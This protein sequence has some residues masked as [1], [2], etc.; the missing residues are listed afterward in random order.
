MATSSGTTAVNAGLTEVRATGDGDIHSV[1]VGGLVGVKGQAVFAGSG[2]YNYIGNNVDAIVKNQ[3]LKSNSSVGVVAQSDDRLYN[4]AGGFAIG[5]NT[6]VGLGAAVSINKITGSTN[7]L[8]SGGSLAAADSGSVKVTRPQDDNLFTT[9]KLNLTTDRTKLSENR[10]EEEKT[11]IVVDSS[12]THTLI[13]QLS[14]GGVAASGNVGINLDG[15]VNLN[16]IEGKTT[17]K[18]QDAALNT[19]NKNSDVNVNAVDYTNIGSFTGTP[20]VGVGP[21]LG[22][23]IGVSA[24]W[25]TLGRTTAAEI[26]SASGKKDVYAKNL[27]VDATAKHGSSALSF[28]AAAGGGKVGISSGDSIVR[29]KYSNTVNALMKDVNA[30][31]D[32]TAEIKADHLAN[33]HMQNISASASGGMV[34][35]SAGAGVSVID[36][37]TTVKAE[38]ADSDLKAKESKEGKNISVQA[39]NENNWKDTLVTASAAVGI[40]A[41]L[42]ANVAI[43]NTTGETSALVTRSNLEAYKVDVTA[44]DKLTATTTGGVGALGLVGV[45]VS[46][47]LNNINSSVNARVTDGTVK[48]ANDINVKAEEE[49]KFDSSVTG[50]AVG[51][52]GVGVNVAVTSINKGITEAQL[53]T[54]TNENGQ[55]MGTDAGTKNEINVHLNGTTVGDKK[56][57]GVNGAK[58]A[59]G[60]DGV[61]FFGISANSKE[62]TDA[63][64]VQV[65]LAV[66]TSAADQQGV[67]TE[68]SGETMTAAGD[69]NVSAKDANRIFEKNLE[70]TV[71]GG[72]STSVA[73]NIIHTN[74]DTDVTMNNASVT[75]KNVT[76]NATQTDAQTDTGKGSEIEVK[77]G[78]GALGIGVGVGYA[79][80]VNRGA[81]DVN[82]SDS[83]LKATSGNVT[84]NALD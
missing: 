25:E 10:K 61:K 37:T 55:S 23:S 1:G 12:A 79:G 63:K 74:Y 22:L 18:I 62:L 69:V 84:V 71:G 42:A 70:V 6:K 28:A 75:G 19:A 9:E 78:T 53:S 67:H 14:S 2:S 11:G 16:T 15:T 80:I 56:Y 3:N 46:V 30:V 31:F 49:R 58:G 17:A 44:K 33:S 40:G 83:T 57:G 60:V 50:V 8:V 39:T 43:N 51:G 72:I 66:P 48:A 41:G 65:S 77:A 24:N 21:V 4:F 34:A 73:D 64:N 36:D 29:H 5:A 81:T 32:G 26:S 13:S 35:V 45:G 7:A 82:I 68:V 47:A 27:A 38:V 76:I 20:S 54:T 59:L 52:I